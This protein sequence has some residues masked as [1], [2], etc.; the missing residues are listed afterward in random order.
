VMPHSDFWLMCSM[1]CLVEQISSLALT[2]PT[3]S[4][5]LENGLKSS[6]S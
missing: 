3:C 1:Y 4:K 6:D 2:Q 5:S